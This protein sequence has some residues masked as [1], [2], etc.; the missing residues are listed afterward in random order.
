MCKGNPTELENDATFFGLELLDNLRGRLFIK[1]LSTHLSIVKTES[2]EGKR[3]SAAV[4]IIF[5]L[6]ILKVAAIPRSAL[7]II[8][9]H[10]K[11]V[12]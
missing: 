12:D 3:R 5:E 8:D 11:I 4:L 7:K 9:K 6:A 2:V 10:K 1:C